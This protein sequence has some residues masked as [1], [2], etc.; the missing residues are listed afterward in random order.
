MSSRV[1]IAFVG[2][3]ALAAL[4]VATALAWATLR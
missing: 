1:A 3:S 2:V 4:S